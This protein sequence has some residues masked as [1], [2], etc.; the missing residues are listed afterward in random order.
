MKMKMMVTR[1]RPKE[2]PH[3]HPT[4]DRNAFSLG[5][6]AVNVAMAERWSGPMERGGK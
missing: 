6:V 5:T 3:P 4:P 1:R 2:W